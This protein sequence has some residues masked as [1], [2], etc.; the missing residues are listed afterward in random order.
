LGAGRAA[1][2]RADGAIDLVVL[3]PARDAVPRFG[4]ATGLRVLVADD[5][6]EA[7]APL[8]D[9]AD[10]VLCRRA[11]PRRFAHPVI[12]AGQAPALLRFDDGAELRS[13]DPLEPAGARIRLG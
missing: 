12:H 13:I 10:L 5:A 3:D 7:P 11:P 9:G 2:T 6:G 8:L 4:V 1:T